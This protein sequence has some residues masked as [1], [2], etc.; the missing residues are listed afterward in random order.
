M[1]IIHVALEGYAA[2]CAALR[3]ET[4]QDSPRVESI[5]R[6]ILADV[7]ARGDGALLA[8]SRQFDAPDL[9]ALEVDRDTWEAGAAEVAPTLRNALERAAEN[10]RAFHRQQLKTSWLD[11]QPGRIVGQTVRPLDRV[12]VYVP[13]GT[14]AYPSTALMAALPAAVAGVPEIVLCTPARRDGTVH[15]LVLLAAKHAGVRRLFTIGGAQAVA[16]MAY[17]TETVPVVDKIVGPG[18]VYVNVAK[19]MLWGVVDIDMLAGPSEVCVVADAGANP[20]FVAL[21]LL[22]QAEHDPECAAFLITPSELLARSVDAEIESL[23]PQRLRRDM[24]RQAL[25]AR[26]AILVT[27]S[28]SQAYDLAN[29]CAPEHLALMVRDPFAAL[30]CIRNAGA[31]LL[32]DYT[33]QTLGDY[34]AGPSHTLPTSG[35]ARFA[36]PLHVDTFL[37]KSSFIH[38]T[39]EALE[40]V[41]DALIALADAEGFETHAEAV[42]VR[43]ECGTTGS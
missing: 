23:L 40:Q 31:V 1:R 39:A 13:G 22:T 9:M 26:C 16:A 17:G 35:T 25:D 3:R 33:P 20:C 27:E 4:L 18:N 24:L 37:K 36:S 11:V 5:V 6:D 21:D 30:G 2:A 15:P 12:G 32:G 41:A 43:R 7:R 34:L 29:V 38:Y 8:L 14:A 42:R 19:K 10:I 28:I